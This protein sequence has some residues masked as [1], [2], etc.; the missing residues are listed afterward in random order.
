MFSHPLQFPSTHVTT[1]ALQQKKLQLV[2]PTPS[3]SVGFIRSCRTKKQTLD[4]IPFCHIGLVPGKWPSHFGNCLKCIQKKIL[5]VYYI[6]SSELLEY[7]TLKTFFSA[8]KFCIMVSEWSTKGYE[9]ICTDLEMK[10][11]WLPKNSSES[12]LCTCD[13]QLSGALAPPT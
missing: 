7:F 9:E 5:L 1:T 13:Q 10:A 3:L 11:L 2:C 4:W 12:G 6:E 8:F